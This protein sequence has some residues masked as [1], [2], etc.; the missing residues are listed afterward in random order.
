MRFG[1]ESTGLRGWRDRRRDEV[2]ALGGNPDE[3][4]GSPREACCV[5]ASMVRISPL[6]MGKRVF[7]AITI[8]LRY[9]R[10]CEKVAVIDG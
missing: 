2:K 9:G 3:P 10:L 1:A 6:L 7:A 5:T 4:S 8:S